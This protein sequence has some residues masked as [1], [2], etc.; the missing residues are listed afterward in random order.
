MPLSLTG[1]DASATLRLADIGRRLIATLPNVLVD[2]LEVAAYV[3]CADQRVRRG[4]PAARNLGQE[5]RRSL[6]FVVPVR[7]PDR[8]S[9]PAVRDALERLLGFM[10]DENPRFEFIGARDPPSPD[11]YLD[12]SGGEIGPNAADEVILFSG[13]LDSLA[14]AVDRLSH[15]SSRLLLVSHQSSTKIAHRQRDLAEALACRFPNRVLHVPVQTNLVGVEAVETTQRSRSFLFGALAAAVAQIAGTGRIGL[16]ENGIVSL[17]LPIASQ[18]VGAAATRTTHPRVVRDLAEFLS[19]LLNNEVDVENPYLWKTKSEVMRVLRDSGHAD[20]VRDTVSCSR[21]YWMTR[22]RTHCGRC[23]Q[24]LDRR[25]AA[26]AASLGEDDP[27]EMYEVDLL[28]GARDDEFD[29]TMAESFLRHALELGDV[30][31]RAFLSRFAGELGRVVA[32]VPEMSADDVART[33]LDMHRR[34]AASVRSVLEDGYHKHAGELAAQTLPPSC[35][36]RLVAGPGGIVM[37]S[38]GQPLAEPAP[39]DDDRDFTRT[40]Q[41]RLALDLTKSRVLIEGVPPIEGSA[42]FGLVQTLVS[43]SERDRLQGL[44]PENHTFRDGHDLAGALGVS[45]ASMRRC[46]YRIRRHVA[47]AFEVSAGLPLSAD[48]VIE[49]QRWRG[50]RLNPAVLILAPQQ[51]AAHAEDHKSR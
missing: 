3:Y 39:T 7:E 48:A 2:L 26:L 35:L 51:L 40:S 24:C 42:N 25:F 30:T 36:L 45:A 43:Q 1:P 28:T 4:G 32:C 5:W 12:L 18:V 29:R 21:V 31:E 27:A 14:G 20:L 15:G 9:S 41:I 50:Y 22:M 11:A 13:G 19:I 47:N 23:S 49:N 37:P 10:S 44:A 6:R 8:W 34:H 46:I 17:N 33:A 16:F 38:I